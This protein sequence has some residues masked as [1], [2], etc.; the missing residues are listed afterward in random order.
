[1]R[2]LLLT[3]VVALALSGQA[4]AQD[5]AAL[6]VVLHAQGG[7]SELW[8]RRV[9]RR[10]TSEGLETRSDDAWALE[11]GADQRE[12]YAALA[13]VEAALAAAR[14]AM[15]GFDEARALTLLAGART[16][17]TRAFSLAGSTAWA[18]EVELAIG[19]IAAQGGA[20][21]L[22]R[23]SFTRGFGLVPT[24]ALGAA[25][26]APD[27][28]ALADQ[29]LRDVRAEPAARFDVEVSGAEGALVF[30]DDQPL[31]RAPGHVQ[32]RA[33]AHVLRVEAEG[34]EP[35]AAWIDVLP[36]TRPALAVTLSPTPLVGAL[37]AARASFA[38]GDIDAVPAQV[39][40]ID[41]A[42][43]APTIVW[44]VEGGSGPFE[45]AL[46]TPCDRTHCHAPSRLEPGSVE[47]PSAAL[48]DETT[49]PRRRHE[50]I[51]WLDEALPLEVALPP[52]VD[53]WSEGWP[54][55]LVGT[56]AALVIGGV[57]AGVVVATQPPP[58]HQLVV[59][60][61]FTP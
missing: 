44:L 51:A 39:R 19:R 23:A 60:P 4:H 11:R 24:R 12:A 30:L 3:A 22:A 53:P 1:M 36:G 18:A 32:T 2:T 35:Y 31:G 54:W 56:G 9:E 50:A 46:A 61:T 13:R 40:A 48:D 55:A 59:D 37:R 14:E 42:L 17:A 47:S 45:R 10:L 5:E 34:A 20:E 49:G 43:G 57:I 52:P 25:E 33:G 26:A 8:A 41:A 29:V 15:R 6:H 16:D 27:V 7:A 21:D 38:G 28:V 58:Q